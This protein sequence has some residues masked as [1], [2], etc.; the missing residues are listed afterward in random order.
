M[1]MLKRISVFIYDWHGCFLWTSFTVLV[2]SLS[3]TALVM[4][5]CGWQGEAGTLQRLAWASLVILG[6][7]PTACLWFI[8]V[9]VTFGYCADLYLAW[10]RIVED[11]KIDLE[12]NNDLE[13]PN[14]KEL[15]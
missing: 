3:L 7:L 9:L 4:H 15:K 11:Q 14:L 12:R 6:G 10:G 1:R 5:F 13:W 2:H 8:G